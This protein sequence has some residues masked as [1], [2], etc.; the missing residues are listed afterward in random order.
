[1]DWGLETKKKQSNLFLK[2]CHGKEDLF[3]Y[4]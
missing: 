4:N 2:K 3:S 1:M